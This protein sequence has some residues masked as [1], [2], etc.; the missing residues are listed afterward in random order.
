MILI[1][2]E[3]IAIIVAIKMLIYTIILKN[4]TCTAIIWIPTADINLFI[5]LYAAP[6]SAAPPNPDDASI[7]PALLIAFLILQK[8][9]IAKRKIVNG[10]MR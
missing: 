5:M 6:P 3:N 1:I 4:A 7:P 10:I 2:T 8:Y 9:N